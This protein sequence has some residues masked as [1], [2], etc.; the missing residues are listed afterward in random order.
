MTNTLLTDKA[1]QELPLHEDLLKAL[2]DAGL[3]HCTPIQAETLPLMLGGRDIAGQ[4]QT[5]TGKTAAFLLATLNRLLNS[6]PADDRRP[7][8]PRALMIA[9]T[10]ELAIQ[11]HKDALLLNKYAGF[12][13]SLVYGGVDYDKQRDELRAGVDILIGTPGR[14]IDYF[15]QKVYDLRAAEMMVLDEADRMFDLGFIKDVR[16]LLRRLPPVDRRQGLLFSATLPYKVT[17]LAYEHMNNPEL[18]KV[19]PDQVTADRVTQVLYHVSKDEK[20]RLL[21]GLLKQ[22]DPKR[23]MIFVNT[24]HVAEKVWGY[25]ESNGFH[26]AMLSGDVPQQKRQKMFKQFSDG[27]LAI[28]VATD[29]ASR[30]L[31]IPNVSHVFNYDLPQ[32]AEDYVHRIG[33]TARVGEAGDAISLACEEYVYSLMEIEEYIGYKLPT[34]S[35]TDA[36]LEKNPAPPVRRERDRKPGG[37]RGGGKRRGGGGRGGGSHRRSGASSAPH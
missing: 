32:N 23:T 18:I 13:I 15:K 33:R 4:A 34:E 29:V 37:G 31:H 26:A 8:Q 36:M 30:G 24:K 25:L 7:N 22:M 1:F 21:L 6:P 11:I 20:I 17:E 16:Y 9:P 19:N 12:R 5:G 35:V 10:R 28:L 27:E 3:T 2:N 14:L